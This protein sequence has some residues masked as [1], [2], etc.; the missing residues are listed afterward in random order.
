MNWIKLPI[1]VGAMFTAFCIAL[2]W[3][4]YKRDGKTFIDE[5]AEVMVSVGKVLALIALFIAGLCMV[6]TACG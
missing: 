2:A 4:G 5:L 3:T 1:G 6:F